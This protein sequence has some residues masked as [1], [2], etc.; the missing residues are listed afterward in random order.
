MLGEVEASGGTLPGNSTVGLWQNIVVT[1]TGAF[2]STLKLDG[3][4]LPV[5]G[6]FDVNGLA[7][8]GTGN[9]TTFTYAR[10]GK[11]T[12]TLALHLGLSGTGQ[13]TGSVEQSMLSSVTARST[14]TADRAYYGSGLK[15]PS[16]LAG[17]L[18]TPYTLAFPSKAQ[19]PVLAP[20]AYPQGDGYATL[21]VNVNGTVTLS[22]RLA[23]HTAISASAPLT[24]AGQWPVFAQL[25]ALNGCF[26]GMATLTDADPTTAD[27]TATDL[28]WCRPAQN[29]QWYK[30]G[31]PAGI[32]VDASGARYVV[33]PATP[34]VSVFPG[35]AATSPNATL[36]FI[37]GQLTGPISQDLLITTTNVA[38]AVPAAPS[39]TLVIT[40]ATGL[41]TGSFNHTDG[42]KP[43]YQGAILQKGASKGAHGYFMTVS[44]KVLNYL[45]ESGAVQV[46]AK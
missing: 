45:G 17:T 23:D 43:T 41:V 20:S 22:G 24:K 6:K 40:K 10:T 4:S 2:T 32:V 7:R 44:P 30:N 8:F 42:T 33:P 27:V 35:L 18:S 29:V 16:S 12:L 34:A 25:Y 28:L 37:G 13:I 3:L 11:P 9:A 1:S 39:P 36:Q 46:L 21:T 5:P 19:T 31:W 26:A 15:V 38:N 14:V